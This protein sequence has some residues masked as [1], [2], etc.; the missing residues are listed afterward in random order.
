MVPLIFVT[1]LVR[2]EDLADRALAGVDIGDDLLKAVQRFIGCASNSFG[3]FIELPRPCRRPCPR[4]RIQAVDLGD[5]VV[6]GT[7]DFTVVM[8]DVADGILVR[9]DSP[10]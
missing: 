2:L 6:D 1:Q 8:Q 5:R 4:R 7:V 10:R 9:S 3:S